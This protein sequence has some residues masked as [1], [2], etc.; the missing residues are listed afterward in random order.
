MAEKFKKRILFVGMPDMAIIVLTKLAA[1]NVNIV[2]CIPPHPSHNTYNL[3]C[4]FAKNLGFEVID[5]HDS[6]KEDTFLNKLRSLN[7]DLAVVASYNKRLPVE[8]LETAK[9]G[10]INIHP[11]LLP[12]YRG[13]NPY[14]NVILND[15]KETGVTL[16]YMDEDFDTG[17][18]IVQKKVPIYE[19]DT[20]GTVFN[21]LNFLGADMLVSVLEKYENGETLPRIKQPEGDFVTAP[22]IEAMSEQT[23]INWN[24]SAR[25]I[26]RQ[27]RALNPFISVITTYRGNCLKLHS[28]YVEDYMSG[29][30][31][32]TIVSADED[33]AV[34]TKKG[35]LHITVL[36]AGTYFVGE[37][38]EFIRLT[39]CKTGEILE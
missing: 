35:T 3:F 12:K 15:E 32:G 33:L 25:D 16:H 23:F 27:I 22:S 20:M 36:Q 30:K 29:F 19:T 4:S 10:F 24:N 31:P 18:I 5:W 39:N 34:A 7:I 2:G 26:E 28:A 14:S 1:E 11:S 9:D 21:R 8:M 6:L 13:G 17:D 38:K 37:A